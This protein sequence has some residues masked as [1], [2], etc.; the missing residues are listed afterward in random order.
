MTE[1][2]YRYLLSDFPESFV[3]EWALQT[4]LNESADISKTVSKVQRVSEQ[5]DYVDI[6]FDGELTPTEID[7]VGA[8]ISAHVAWKRPYF[9]DI[10]RRTQE[11]IED[12]F[13]YDG[14][15]FSASQA[16]QD[17]LTILWADENDF[18]YPFNLAA[19][20][21]NCTPYSVTSS[22]VLGAIVAALRTHIQTHVTSGDSLKA[23]IR[24]ATTKSEADAVEDTR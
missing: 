23:Q 12:G 9:K 4:S 10:D 5:E 19:K 6:Y 21:D 13:S 1:Q 15:V 22:T 11:L 20:C 18:S 16:A 7:A 8:I 14:T 3:D 2:L 17:K 24:S